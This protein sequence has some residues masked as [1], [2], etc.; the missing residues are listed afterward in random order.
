M[1]A[2][3]RACLY[4]RAHSP[5]T[6]TTVMILIRIMSRP[7]LIPHITNYRLSLSGFGFRSASLSHSLPLSC[8]LDT[9][10]M[11]MLLDSLESG[12]LDSSA[13]CWSQPELRGEVSTT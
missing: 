9:D 12:L 10:I 13:L 11:M 1:G 6:N 2:C 5:N 7:L 3:V 8:S 4:V